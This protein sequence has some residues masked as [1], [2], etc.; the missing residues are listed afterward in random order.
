MSS[1]QDF[2]ASPWQVVFTICLAAQWCTASPVIHDGVLQDLKKLDLNQAKLVAD[3]STLK[4]SLSPNLCDWQLHLYEGHSFTAPLL[5]VVQ[6]TE[7][8]KI[9]APVRET[10][11]LTPPEAGPQLFIVAEV[12]PKPKREVRRKRKLARRTP[13]SYSSEHRFILLV[14]H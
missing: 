1:V 7:A 10:F 11:G 2:R 4:C 3:N 9:T 5:P 13:F 14:L 6:G 12:E 8:Q